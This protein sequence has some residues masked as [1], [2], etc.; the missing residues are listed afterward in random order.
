LRPEKPRLSASTGPVQDVIECHGIEQ[1]F[2]N[3]IARLRKLTQ[4][5]A[6]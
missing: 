5:L 4:Y 2:G 6:Q 3:R 1:I